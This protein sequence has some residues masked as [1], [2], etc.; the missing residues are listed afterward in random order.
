VTQ[1]WHHFVATYDGST[2]RIYLDGSLAASQPAALGLNATTASLWVGASAFDTAA[3][4]NGIVDEVA[5]YGTA[6]S[7]GRITAHYHASGR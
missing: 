2:T 1:V 7:A 5:V 3:Y 6:L 4:F